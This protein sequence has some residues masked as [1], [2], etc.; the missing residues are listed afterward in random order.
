MYELCLCQ[1]TGVKCYG[2]S[3]YAV[4]SINELL[5]LEAVHLEFLILF[6]I[7]GRM[8]QKLT[9]MNFVELKHTMKLESRKLKNK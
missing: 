1:V 4:F 6:I 3:A 8:L 7:Y 5:K 2:V 9:R